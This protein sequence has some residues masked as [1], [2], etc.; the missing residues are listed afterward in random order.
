MFSE[1]GWLEEG[2]VKVVILLMEWFCMGMGEG[3]GL[4]E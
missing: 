4:G 2:D 3:E 1:G